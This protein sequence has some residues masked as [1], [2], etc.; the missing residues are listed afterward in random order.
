MVVCGCRVR[1]LAAEVGALGLASGAAGGCGVFLRRVK[2]FL[3]FWLWRVQCVVLW[4]GS[5]R[6]W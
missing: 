2:A 3:F 6:V 4:L 1:L 5:L